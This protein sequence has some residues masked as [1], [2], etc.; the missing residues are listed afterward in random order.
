MPTDFATALVRKRA[1]RVQTEITVLLFC[2]IIGLGLMV[3][4]LA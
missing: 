4:F 1:T 2:L 3:E